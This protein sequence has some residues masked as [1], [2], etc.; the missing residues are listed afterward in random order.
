[1]TPAPLAA[2]ALV[3]GL[4][5][6][7]HCAAMCG[8]LSVCMLGATGGRAPLA[9]YHAA[10]IAGYAGGGTLAGA[11]GEG[12]A[13][14]LGP[15]GGAALAWAIAAA[16]TLGV[17]GLRPRAGSGLAGVAAAFARRAASL[18]PRRRALALGALTP[19]LPCGLLIGMYGLAAAAGSAAHGGITMAAFAAGTLP[20]LLTAQLGWGG[21]RA[22]LSRALL[23]RGQQAAILLSAL[24]LVYRGWAALQGASC[25]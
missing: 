12:A 17:L 3:F 14:G 21:L 19:L 13:R 8:P 6:S 2:A 10:R 9:R 5:S 11:L 7:L 18:P 20:G 16:L 1:M 4:S 24:V 23:A 15:Y 22:V 25:H